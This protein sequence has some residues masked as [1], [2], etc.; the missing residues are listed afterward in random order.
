MKKKCFVFIAW[1]CCLLP[2]TIFAAGLQLDGV[3]LASNA[4]QGNLLWNV[5][6]PGDSEARTKVIS[7]DD[8]IEVAKAF[9]LNQL[10]LASEQR[11]YKV[12]VLNRPNDIA[13]PEGNVV[14][15]CKLPYGIK[16]GFPTNVSVLV[17]VDGQLY[18]KTMVRIKIHL[19]APVVVAARLLNANQ[20]IGLEDVRLEKMDITKV[21]R[22]YFTDT[23]KVIG[24]VLKRVVNPGTMINALMVGKPIIVER[25]AMVHIVSVNGEIQVKTEGQALQ[26]G[27]EGDFI[28][29]KNIRS[30][31]VVSG[32]VIDSVTVEVSA[33]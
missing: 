3:T 33:R 14:Y 24:M 28:R 23:G 7:G 12:E 31:K 10:T 6:S 30:N 9:L 29:V 4:V 32:K 18:K 15:E 26:S 11:E 1:L 19:F 20:T 22:Y 8:F 2:S 21:G 13:V 17:Y 16:Y 5:T 27:R 25:M